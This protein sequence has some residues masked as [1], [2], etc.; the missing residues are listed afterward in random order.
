MDKTFDPRRLDVKAFAQAGAELQ[1]QSPLGQ[2]SRLLDE[3]MAG[4]QAQGHLVRWH[5]EGQM[6]P[7]TGG[8]DRIGMALSAEV[9]LP[10]QCQRCLG[11]VVETVKAERAFVFV[12]DEA[13]AEAMDEESEEDVLVI[14]RD[15]DALFLVEDE[16]ILALPL[17]PRHEVCAQN[18]PTEAVDEAFEAASERPN[19]FAALAALKKGD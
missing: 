14:S 7:I 6:A 12:A 16:L 9:D 19:P 8:G 18:L 1:G 15:F 2:W 11:P 10:M 5:L 13:T 17:V 4:T 3:K